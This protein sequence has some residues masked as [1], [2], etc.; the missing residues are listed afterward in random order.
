[1]TKAFLNDEEQILKALGRRGLLRN[2]ALLPVAAAVVAGTGI[3]PALADEPSPSDAS[4]LPGAKAP[5]SA[6]VQALEE[7]VATLAVNAAT[8]AAPIV[9]MY[10]LRAAVCF[11]TKP[12]AAPNT[13]WR[14]EDISTPTLSAESGYVSP[15]VNVVYGF[16]FADLAAEPV[17]LSAP[18][19]DG[20]Y[21]M[22]EIVDMWTNAFAYPAGKIA[23]YKGGNF[24]LVGPGWQ[25]TLPAGVTRIDCPTRWIELQPRVH[26]PTEA[27][28]DRARTVLK[29][30]TLKGLAEFTGGTA[31]AAPTYNYEVPLLNKKI[32][33]SHF[34]FN[35]P[36]QFWSIFVAAL[37]ENPP[38]ASEIASVLPQYKYLG[39]EFGK[40]WSAD[41][42]APPILAQMKQAAQKIAGMALGTMPIVGRLANGWVIPP[43]NVAAAGSDYLSRADVAVFGLTANTVI[44]AIYYSGILDGNNEP[45]TGAKQ[46]TLTIS[47]DAEFNRPVPPG[48]W[49]V[50]MYDKVTSFSVPNSINRYSLGGD[51]D[52]V[53]NTDGSV[54]LYLQTDSPGAD[55]E[56][57]WLPAPPGPFYLI[58]RNYAPVPEVAT[59]LQDIATFQGPPGVIPVTA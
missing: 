58:L 56:A 17:I 38:P 25:G 18:D 23:G 52:L 19:S 45:M 22:I 15:N 6:A 11:G 7:W 14:L 2:T 33:S 30:V 51:N 46:Y 27:G 31:P 10:N 53:K 16:G 55:K 1:M 28:L 35:D 41:G 8:Y 3:R 36:M 12:K 50:T 43:A 29:A 44:E 26:V 54:T 57:N 39:I 24:A 37:N 40:P 13:F 42:V 5:P 4:P 21:Y 59:G 20:L 47:A 48:F 32:A 9:A 49:S 34:P